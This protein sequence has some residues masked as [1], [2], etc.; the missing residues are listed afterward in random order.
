MIKFEESENHKSYD[1]CES[2]F[3][4]CAD[5][6]SGVSNTFVCYVHDNIKP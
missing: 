4:V 5:A 1:T 2:S 3:D 6:S